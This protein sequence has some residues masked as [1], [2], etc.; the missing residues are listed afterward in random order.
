MANFECSAKHPLGEICM[1]LTSQSETCSSNSA[2]FFPQTPVCASFHSTLLTLQLDS[3]SHLLLI[4]F[5]SHRSNVCNFSVR[6]FLRRL[7]SPSQDSLQ[8]VH[9]SSTGEPSAGCRTA[10]VSHQCWAQGKGCSFDL[11]AM[12]CLMQPRMLWTARAHC[13]LV[14]S[15]STRIPSMLSSWLAP[16]LYWSWGL[17]TPMFR[18]LHFPR[19]NSL[20]FQSAHLSSPL[21]TFW[22]ARHNPLVY[23]P[24]LQ[25]PTRWEYTLYHYQIINED[26]KQYQ[27]QYEPWGIPVVTALQLDL[28]LL[29]RLPSVC[30]T[31]LSSPYLINLSIKMFQKTAAKALLK[32]R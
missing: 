20:V 8:Y 30:L 32:M 26:I 18:T 28:E 17:S 11:T 4:L 6:D 29:I 24:L 23:Q 31:D 3:S 21:R 2:G 15:L 10:D 25:V 12:L 7:C 1:T 19:L 27:P 5:P 22:L 14:V 13:W 9:V 16:N